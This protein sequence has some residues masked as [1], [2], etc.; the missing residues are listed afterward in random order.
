MRTKHVVV[1]SAQ[2]QALQLIGIGRA[3]I[4]KTPGASD[5]AT[6]DIQDEDLVSQGLSEFGRRGQ[7]IDLARATGESGRRDRSNVG[8]NELQDSGRQV[9]FGSWRGRRFGS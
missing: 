1:Q 6:L 8:L 4:Q 5:I 2:S 3:I 9:I 7:V